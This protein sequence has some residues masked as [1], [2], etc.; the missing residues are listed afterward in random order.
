MPKE[1]AKA[2]QEFLNGSEKSPGCASEPSKG[3]T[4]S[5]HFLSGCAG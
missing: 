5:K 3:Q 2:Q 4:L 1:N